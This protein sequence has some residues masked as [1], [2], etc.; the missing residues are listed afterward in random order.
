MP[1][2]RRSHARTRRGEASRHEG[3]PLKDR[4]RRSGG[5]RG[6]SSIRLPERSGHA[7]SGG[8][9]GA[10]SIRLPERSGH[11]RVGRGARGEIYPP[12]G[13]KRTRAGRARR[14]GRVLSAFRREADARRSGEARGAGSIRLPKRS[15]HAPAPAGD[16]GA[17]AP[18]GR[19]R[20]DDASPHSGG[21]PRDRAVNLVACGADGR[22]GS[23]EAVLR[24]LKPRWMKPRSRRPPRSPAAPRIGRS[25]ATGGRPSSA[26]APRIG[27][28]PATGGRPSS[29]ALADAGKARAA[30]GRPSSPAVPDAGSPG[31]HRRPGP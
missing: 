6:A 4:K 29:P 7:R 13:E 30:G 5:A 14:A 17:P 27:R 26:A 11:A 31:S 16:A 20:P 15:G 22:S 28:R 8:A 25:P 19:A 21:S 12:S 1:E 24:R 10:S 18:L 3:L 23:K 9:R 2:R